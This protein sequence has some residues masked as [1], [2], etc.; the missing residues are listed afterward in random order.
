[1]DDDA[2]TVLD[3]PLFLVEESKR[4]SQ[5]LIWPLQ[6]KF[7]DE[8]SIDAWRD[9][10][11]PHYVTSN[12]FIARAYARMVFGY[13]RD[14]ARD[15]QHPMDPSQP[16]Y[17]LELG[18]GSGRFSYHFIKN[19][20]DVWQQSTLSHVPVCYVI[21]DFCEKNLNFWRQHPFLQPYLEQGLLDFALVDVCTP[22]DITL[23]H[24]G[25]TLAQGQMRNPLVAIANYVF[26]S[27]EQDAFHVAD[28]ALHESLVSLYSPDHE[29]DVD[30][31]S[32][33]QRLQI[34][35]QNVPTDSDYYPE[36]ALNELLAYYQQHVADGHLLLPV[37]AIRYL[38]HLRDLSNNRLLL[39]C[40]DKGHSREEDFLFYQAPDLVS[41]GSVS[42]SVNFHALGRYVTQQDGLFLTPPQRHQGLHICAALFH[43]GAAHRSGYRQDCFLETQQAFA[44]HIG[45][46]NPDDFYSLKCFIQGNAEILD[47]GQL[48]A[49][50]RMS[51]WDAANFWGCYSAFMQQAATLEGPL[52][53]D[54]VHM[55]AKVWDSYYPLGEARDLPFALGSLLYEIECYAEAIV[56]LEY[57]LAF[58]GRETHTL[59]NLGMCYYNLRDLPQ[60]LRHVNGALDLD[61]Q[62]EPAQGMLTAIHSQMGSSRGRAPARV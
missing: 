4:L 55:V 17:I 50:M 21:T 32:L 19:F 27:I 54:I 43:A 29:A 38:G 12:T 47:L 10:I 28:G 23:Y 26:D 59:Y 11:V 36:A 41:H 22:G 37:Q 44:E 39:I 14:A 46:F 5:S 62:Y 57:S 24:S 34:H 42:L 30:D 53:L 20:F 8:Q 9:S 49:Y 25:A 40:G 58:Y 61:P 33:L 7:F 45:Q 52:K 15:E 35:W 48:L 13:L 16:L 56:Y 60:A 2:T 31:A 3:A 1:M 18:A 51:G 6:R